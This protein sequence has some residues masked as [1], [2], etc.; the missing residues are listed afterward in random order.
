MVVTDGFTIGR[1]FDAIPLFLQDS[2]IPSSFHRGIDCIVK[3]L[4]AHLPFGVRIDP[5][6]LNV[7]VEK[8]LALYG[9]IDHGVIDDHVKYV[10]RTQQS[11]RSRPS[12]L[13]CC[14]M[15]MFAAIARGDK[16]NLHQ[17]AEKLYRVYGDRPAALL[18][19]DHLCEAQLPI[20]T[21]SPT[22]L[23]ASLSFYQVY[24]HLLHELGLSRD[25]Y[26]KEGV[27]RLFGFQQL[28]EESRFFIPSITS[29]YQETQKARHPLTQ[30]FQHRSLGSGVTVPSR[31]LSDCIQRI[32]TVRL[33]YVEELSKTC[34]RSSAFSICI[35]HASSKCWRND[36]GRQHPQ[37]YDRT[38]YNNQIRLHLQHALV[39]EP[40]LW[41]MGG[42]DRGSHRR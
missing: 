30:D 8:Y 24:A 31:H 13:N 18:S 42:A 5:L 36:C 25:M 27:A 12:Y 1:P 17:I 20:E 3:G 35:T 23:L 32:I 21:M 37:T 2:S 15:L 19:L 33:S 7:H 10:V 39:L 34:R 14:Q 29:L 11:H 40:V 4:W 6:Q 28:K 22:E 41:R 38:W 26:R 16:T 9:G